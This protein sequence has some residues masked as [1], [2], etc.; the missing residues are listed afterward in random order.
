MYEIGDIL[1]LKSNILS[2]YK[3]VYISNNS[4]TKKITLDAT[5]NLLIEE[6]V[7]QL[8]I[9]E[10]R[11]QYI[12]DYDLWGTLKQRTS[13][14]LEGA[15]KLGKFG[16]NIKM[17][18]KKIKDKYKHYEITDFYCLEHKPELLVIKLG[19][20]GLKDSYEMEYD[21]LEQVLWA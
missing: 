3:I 8:S 15:R 5:L 13:N 20:N 19:V 7:R 18:E 6:D 1:T 12:A 17:Y 9:P 2:P 10:P 4:P 14:S 21:Y 16:A 11:L